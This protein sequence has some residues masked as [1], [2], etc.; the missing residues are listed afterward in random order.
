MALD[1]ISWSGYDW[2]KQE[3]W[4][5]IHPQKPHWWYDPTKVLIDSRDVLHLTTGFNPKYF[6]EI[7]Y[8]SPIGVGLVSCTTP[9]SYGDFEISA[10]LPQGL[11]LWPAF[12]LWSFSSWPPEIDILEGFSFFSPDFRTIPS[13]SLSFLKKLFSGKKRKTS[14]FVLK[15]NLH[16]LDN[17]GEKISL[18]TENPFRDTNFFTKKDLTATFVTYKLEWHPEVIKIWYDDILMLFLKKGRSEVEDTIFKNLENQKMNVIINNG[19]TSF[20]DLLSPPES[21]FS[22]EYFKY[23]PYLFL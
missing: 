2:I 21:D 16:Y 10:K 8:T 15:R 6:T 5:Q 18:N 12:W 7:D 1:T 11:N 17:S 23:T 20:V 9:F 4:G 19:V 3:R 22:I 14:E 13:E